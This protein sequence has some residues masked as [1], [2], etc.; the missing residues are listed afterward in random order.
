VIV[1]V[2]A[3]AQAPAKAPP[4]IVA[5]PEATGACPP[6]APG[7]AGG[8]SG[9]DFLCSEYSLSSFSDV[10]VA[11]GNRGWELVSFGKLAKT[12]LACFRRPR[13]GATKT[14]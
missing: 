2:P 1:P 10:L 5:V 11:A 4:H 7:S 6:G 8:W 9:Y 14:P 13:P 12:D 3:A